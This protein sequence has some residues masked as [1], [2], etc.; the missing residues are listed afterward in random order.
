MMQDNDTTINIE[1]EREGGERREERK[2]MP[3]MMMMQQSKIKRENFKCRT[4]L[5]TQC[6]TS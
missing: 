6:L 5:E 3:M 1:R 2:Q 4:K